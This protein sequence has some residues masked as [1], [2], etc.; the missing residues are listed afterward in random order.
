MARNDDLAEDRASEL[1]YREASAR[2][3][4][5][6]DWLARKDDAEFAALCNRR[7]VAKWLR[8]IRAVGGIRLA[9]F[10]KSKRDWQNARRAADAEAARR[11]DR[12]ARAKKYKLAPVT[13]TC[14]ECGATWC[15]VP[16][17][18]G[19]S[20][21]FCGQNCWQRDRYRTSEAYREM[22]KSKARAAHARKTGTL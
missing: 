2:D 19:L 21:R 13:F 1:G 15:K 3:V 12:A 5:M 7:H 6:S 11:R 8:E 18:R 16:W 9:R 17:V 14:A 22:K 10:L 20:P 4:R